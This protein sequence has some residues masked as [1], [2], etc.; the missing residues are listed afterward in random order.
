MKH[1][2]TDIILSVLLQADEETKL[3]GSVMI[4]FVHIVAVFNFIFAHVLLRLC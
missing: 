1:A 3:V 4:F 2:I